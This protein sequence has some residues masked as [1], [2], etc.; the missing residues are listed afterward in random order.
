MFRQILFDLRTLFRRRSVDRD[1]D[2][3]IQFHIDKEVERH[4]QNGMPE[5]DA[6]R[7]ARLAFG[8]TAQTKEA[9]HDERR[10]RFFETLWQ[11]LKYGLRVLIGKPG[12]TLVA[13]LTLALGIGANTAIFSVIYHVLIR[14]LPYQESHHLVTINHNASSAQ[15]NFMAF[16]AKDFQDY[17]DQ[18]Q[19]FSGIVEHH[20]M[21]FLLLGG[22]QAERTQTGVVS[23]N[24]FD[25]MGVAPLL[26]RSF[27]ESDEVHG[28][29]AV[30]IL[31]HEYWQH[32]HGG[33]PNIIG[34]SFQMNDRPHTVIGVL[35]PIPQYPVKSDVYM[36]TSACPTRSSELFKTNRKQRMLS[37]FGRLKPDVTMEQAQA[38]LSLI[39]SR[40]RQTYPEAYPDGYTVTPVFLQDA[41][42]EDARPTL[43]ILLAT[44]GLVLLLACANVANLSL[45]RLMRREREMAVRSALGAGRGRLIRQLLTESLIVALIGGGLGILLAYAGLDVLTAFVGRFTNRAGEIG[46]DTSVLLFTL[47]VSVIT[48]IVFGLLPALSSRETL[49]PVLREGSGRAT[50]GVS[51]QRLRSGLI[52][53][54][55]TISFM[56]LIGA[57]LMVR[58][59]IKLQQVKPGFDP[60]NVLT[61]RLGP[62]WSKYSTPM[63]YQDLFRRVM[64]R[65]ASLPGVTRVSMGSTFPMNPLGI[66]FGPMNMRF[67]I[68][69]M[70][71]VKQELAPQVDMRSATPGY[72]ETIKLPLLQGRVF[73]PDDEQDTLPVAIIN[74]TMARQYWENEDPV[75]KRFTMNDGRTWITIVGVVGD[76][77]Q[78]GLNQPTMPALYRPATQFGGGFR[79][80]TRTTGDPIT[81]TGSIRQIIRDLDPEVAIDQIQTLVQARDD[82]MAAP[83]TTTILLGLFAVLALVVTAAGIAGVI[84]LSISQRTQEIGVRMAL[85]A[86][87]IAVLGMM[88]RHGM[89]LVLLGMV[90]GGAGAWGL[91]RLMDTMLFDIEPTDPVTF[92]GVSLL[93]LLIAAGACL[94]PARRAASIDPM[95]AL[96][97]E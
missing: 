53:A 47:S 39:G 10:T 46:I 21:S 90:I 8:G 89:S 2:E 57:G 17:R 67:Q 63:Q 25:V 84:A 62:N 56:L 73:T 58:S 13:V 59:L 15:V 85:G 29:E 96:R 61:M 93:L 91:V 52:V 49:E 71:P 14:P 20:G 55:V 48:G 75:G 65:T 31:S 30:L 60:E 19:S 45:A 16:S 42:T 88:V 54:Q 9:Y 44:A 5:A 51:R 43:F 87:R 81:L 70:P 3:E 69:G 68:E 50:A 4:I 23:W 82:S 37:V 92:V 94:I 7:K 1:L 76:V 40:L 27:L 33:D 80:L 78:Y 64:E 32:S 11:D 34:K 26:G 28:A 86:S 66:T 74:R 95:I 6:Q 24:F 79:L 72:F 18:N 83:R 35:P 22:E 77:K 41:L 36:P 97:A 12:F 38:D